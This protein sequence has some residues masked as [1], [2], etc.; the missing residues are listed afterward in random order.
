MLFI[1]TRPIDRALALTQCLSTAGFDVVNLP[2]LA[3]TARPYDVELE[4]LYLQLAKTQIIVVVSPTAVD[5]GMRYLE[6]AGLSIQQ[7]QHIQWVAVGKK[8][9]QL[10]SQFGVESHIPAVETSEGMLSL[11]IFNTL[12][13]LK[14]IAF[15]RGEG[16]RQFMM[17]QCQERHINVLNF[18]LYERYCPSET[19]QLF[20]DFIAN[21]NQPKPYWN[22]ISSE[23]SWKNWLALTERHENI[24]NDCH[25]LV[26]GERLYQLLQHDKTIAQKSFNITQISDLD[27][28][29]ILRRIMQ[30][31]GKL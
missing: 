10:L 31:Q 11:P 8:T 16:G 12:T 22:C 23:A 18:I 4:Q 27:P 2:L 9:A 29:T 19:Q 13:N 14:Q 7:I 28:E 20:S 24:V 25:Y 17:Q 1:N 6:R 26:L 30:L 3:L 21:V 15:W 5:V